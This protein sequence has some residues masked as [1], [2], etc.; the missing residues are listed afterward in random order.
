MNCRVGV[1][2]GKLL[3][4]DGAKS[5]SFDKTQEF[6]GDGFGFKIDPTGGGA[7]IEENGSELI[8]CGCI[9]Y[10]IGGPTCV[11]G[12][13][14]DSSLPT[15]VT[16]VQTDDACGTTWASIFVHD[17]TS[18]SSTDGKASYHDELFKD[19]REHGA[20]F[21]PEVLNDLR[22]MAGSGLRYVPFKKGSSFFKT[23]PP[24]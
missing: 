13:I 18:R 23:L 6:Q 11:A 9:R 17:S 15:G 8:A 10:A 3:S 4:S 14:G 7:V 22:L 21:G 16:N 19:I 2:C 20:I 1:F 12:C 5:Y 24:C